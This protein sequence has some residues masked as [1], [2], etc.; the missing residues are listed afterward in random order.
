LLA[1]SDDPPTADVIRRDPALVLH[2][3]RFLRPTPNPNTLHFHDLA[4]TQPGLCE[5][6]AHLLERSANQP[7][8]N[9]DST[10]ARFGRALAS[11]AAG[12]ADRT[13]SCSPDAAWAAG[14][15]APLGW[16]ALEAVQAD[17]PDGLTPLQIGRRLAN[18][19]R[20]PD[21]LATVIGYPD[22]NEPAVGQLGSHSE[23]FA[24][25][26]AAES[27]LVAQWPEFRPYAAERTILDESLLALAQ[28]SATLGESVPE[29]TPVETRLLARLLRTA[30]KARQRSA[31]VLVSQLE[32]QLDAV[33][34]ELAQ[35]Q[36]AFDR[37]LRDAKLNALAEFTA[38]ASHEINNPLAVIAG[39]VQL[40]ESRETDPERRK[41]LLAIRRQTKRIHEILLSARQFARP[42]QSQPKAFGLAEWIGE[43]VREFET[44][45]GLIAGVE[46]N[47]ELPAGLPLAFGDPTQLRQA[48]SQLL[49]N[50]VDA[51]RPD[52][53]IGIRVEVRGTQCD[54]IV[55][56]SGRGPDPGQVPHLFD[57]FFS[58]KSAGR[59]RGLGLSIAW[60]F[61]QLNQG[62]VAYAPRPGHPSRFVLSFPLAEA[63]PQLRRTA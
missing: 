8:L 50:A 63:D 14:L 9:P 30:A 56:D 18:R 51:A 61:A 29:A 49:R 44:I 45:S 32:D 5:A 28:D 34:A 55:E 15:L 42:P 4:L 27:A 36:S 40:L 54:V 25:V 2:L 41:S 37:T 21:W 31:S 35:L 26:R 17:R 33:A 13:G 3:L 16:Y 58:G 24:L 10:V 38:G 7:T 43:T 11:T 6:A 47:V 60:R 48:L 23:L 22:F 12:M 20:L 62:D 19:W 52:G 59:G 1:L 39:N 57:P 46:L 53:T